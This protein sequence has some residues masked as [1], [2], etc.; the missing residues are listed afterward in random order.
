MIRASSHQRALFKPQAAFDAIDI[1]ITLAIL[2]LWLLHLP[3]L[4]SEQQTPWSL[5]ATSHSVSPHRALS[6]TL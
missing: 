1:A 4:L 3:C 5:E 2:L 6:L